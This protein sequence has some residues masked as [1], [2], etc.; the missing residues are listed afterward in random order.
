[1]VNITACGNYYMSNAPNNTTLVDQWG[2]RGHVI[3]LKNNPLTQVSRAGCDALCG[4]GNDYYDWAQASQTITTWI[5]P[6][7]G[8]ILQAPFE[9]NAFMRTML[10]L[11]RWIG[12]PMASLSY[13]LWNIKVTG[14]CGVFGKRSYIHSASTS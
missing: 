3:G 9:S 11:T 10:A 7:I 12:S 8:V 4:T 1:M 13:V 14:K 2:W 6:V 5:L